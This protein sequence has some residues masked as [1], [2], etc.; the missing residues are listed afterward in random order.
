MKTVF[1]LVDCNNFYVSC[2]RVFDPSLEHRPV[3]VLSNN[4]G[5][6]VARSNEAKALGIQMGTPF[7]KC[8]DLIRKNSGKVFSSNYSLY[9]D[10]SQRVMRTLEQFTP[11]FEIYSIDEA[12]LEFRAEDLFSLEQL[13]RRIKNT[14]RQH[15]GIPISIGIGQT[16]TLAKIANKIAKQSASGTFDITDHPDTDILLESIPCNDVWGVGMQYEKLLKLNGILTARNLKYADDAWLRKKMTVM[17]L[18]T[19][20]EL[21]GISCIPLEMATLSKKGICS[22]RSF[23]KPVE[24]LNELAEAL[25]D[26]TAIA[27]E[28]L[29]KQRSVAP[30]LQ[31]YLST[32]RFKPEPQYSAH[33]TYKLPEATA[34]TPELVRY[35]TACL[36]KIYR[37]GYQYKKVSIFFAGIQPQKYLQPNL[38]PV[39]RNTFAQK[40]RFMNAVDSINGRW[41]SNTAQFAAAGIKKSWRMRRQYTSQHY[42]T[43][44]S[45]LPVVKACKTG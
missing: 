35:A 7:F 39:T 14:I 44:W 28:K 19:V 26:Y 34:Y 41:G 22:S 27:A 10:M 31:V 12:F 11:D 36:G 25:A 33:I 15:T 9:A 32:N 18:R 8:R 21:R 20:W 2:E 1:A 4:D 38:F 5:C 37:P 16:K 24:T 23:G 3:V 13:G 42:T 40:S 43:R 6:V 17:G 30:I 29:R 45:D